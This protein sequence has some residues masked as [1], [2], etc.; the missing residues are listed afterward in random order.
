M[1]GW[2]ASR[3][4]VPGP[5][6]PEDVVRAFHASDPTL[7]REDVVVRDDGWLVESQGERTV[8]LFEFPVAAERCRLTYRAKLM[9]RGLSG[10]AYLEM[11]CRMP[12][13]GE[14][15]SRGLDQC[16]SGTTDWSSCEIPFYAKKGQ[17]IDLVKLNLVIEGMGAVGI[18]DVEVLTTPLG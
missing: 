9:S 3:I 17:H 1:S 6:G 14:F 11:W 2:F 12:G 15:F 5:A 7:S 4:K 18:K 13:R 16:I 8:R 10:R